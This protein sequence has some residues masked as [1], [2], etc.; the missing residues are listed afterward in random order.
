MAIRCIMY[1]L[2]IIKD[3][4]VSSCFY[5]VCGGC[6]WQDYRSGGEE[7][8]IWSTD[9]MEMEMEMTEQR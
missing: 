9:A 7:D 5:V 4:S 8:D 2:G 3:V 6:W 1:I